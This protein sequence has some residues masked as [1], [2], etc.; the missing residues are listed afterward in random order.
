V[1]IDVPDEQ[2]M[3]QRLKPILFLGVAAG[4]VFAQDAPR[5]Q[6]ADSRLE[7]ATTAVAEMMHSPD[8]GIPRDLLDKAQCVVVIPDLLKGAFI[9]GGQYGRGYAV[10][11]HG[12]GWT[13]PAAMRIAG[14]SFGFQLGGSAT[15][16]IMLVMN[17]HGMNRLLS[18]KFTIGGQAEAAA[19]PIGRDTTAQTDIAMHAE[20]LSWSRSR[21]VF[22]GI[23][24]SGAT[25]T[26]DNGENR[27]LYG[28]KIANREILDGEVSVPPAGRQF[29]AE[30]SRSARTAEA[31][32]AR[33]R[34][35]NPPAPL[36]NRRR[37][38][39]A[40][41]TERP[42]QFAEGQPAVPPSAEPV[43]AHVADTLKNNPAWT[44]RIEG[45][46]DNTGS[47]A[48]NMRISK[49]RADA[50][51][52]WLADH[53]VDRKRMTTVGRGQAHPIADNSTEAGRAANRRVEIVR[54]DN[55]M[56]QTG[57]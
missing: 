14:G 48:E 50:V 37:G 18:D 27:R 15:D 1:A 54:S 51:A 10:C 43:L 45:F 36:M 39:Q 35:N 11:R 6:K 23:S 31:A 30:I 26:P 56:R 47:R 16:L 29:V 21:G 33:N 13:A 57:F 53:G 19:G 32:D 17:K 44:I 42:I 38:M 7:N 5:E 20:I 25:L 2:R 46:A 9:V 28:R 49:Q 12:N 22:A 34:V 41:L 3:I 4:M 52:K 55:V 24:L 8:R 40:M